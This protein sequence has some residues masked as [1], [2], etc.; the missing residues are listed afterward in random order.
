[1]VIA[2]I[3]ILIALLLPAV[4]QAREAARRSQC[5]NNLKQLGLALHNY[6][7]VFS[8]FPP[9]YINDWGLVRGTSGNYSGDSQ[10]TNRAQWSWTAMILPQIDQAPTFNQLGVSNR[11]GVEALDDTNMTNILQTS[12]PAFRCPSDPAP[13]VNT[14]RDTQNTAGTT[15]NVATS[16]YVAVNTG[17]RNGAGI[18]GSNDADALISS[19]VHTRG[20]FWGDSKVKMRDVLDGTSN[21]FMVGERSYRYRTGGCNNRGKAALLYVV[22][23]TNQVK[24]PNRGDSDA[25]TTIGRGINREAANCSNDWRSG[26]RVSSQHEG[27]AQFTLADGS[28]RFVSE[29]VDLTTARRLGLKSDGNT[30]GE[31]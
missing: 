2:I 12:L 24:F 1:M 14:D 10:V 31:F 4:Q 5:K 20:M 26:S 7:D 13:D 19:H 22:R 29:N 21:Q 17:H 15:V 27:G 11:R 30:I 3:A 18:G 16:N 6:H 9:G 25:M 8:T 23:A 28:V